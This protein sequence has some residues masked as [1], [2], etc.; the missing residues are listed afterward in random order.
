MANIMCDYKHLSMLSAYAAQKSNNILYQGKIYICV[1]VCV[2]AFLKTFYILYTHI[3]KAI[4]W[5]LKILKVKMNL[6]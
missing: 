6:A 4:L 2:T 5:F 3:C 1:C